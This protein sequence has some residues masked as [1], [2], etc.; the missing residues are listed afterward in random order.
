MSPELIAEELQAV[1]A[2]LAE[3]KAATLLQSKLGFNTKEAALLTSIGQD[4]LR[5]RALSPETSP[6]HVKTLKVGTKYIWPRC[7]LERL[8]REGAR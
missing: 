3:I 5:R 8:L 7:E 1:K 6:L 4:E 2:D